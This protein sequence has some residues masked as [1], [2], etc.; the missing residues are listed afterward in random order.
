MK[1]KIKIP[2][3]PNYVRDDKGSCYCISELND[4]ELISLCQQWT[5]ALLAHAKKRRERKKT[6]TP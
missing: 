5:K 4:N 6:P 1:V 2:M 3:L